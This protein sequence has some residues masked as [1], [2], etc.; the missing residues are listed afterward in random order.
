MAGPEFPNLPKIELKLKPPFHAAL[1][2]ADN[3]LTAYMAARERYKLAVQ[4]AGE[5]PTQTRSRFS[6]MSGMA[7]I[8]RVSRLIGSQFRSSHSQQVSDENAGQPQPD[9]YRTFREAADAFRT[10]QNTMSGVR[11]APDFDANDWRIVNKLDVAIAVAQNKI[12]AGGHIIDAQEAPWLQDPINVADGRNRIYGHQAVRPDDQSTISGRSTIKPVSPEPT[13]L[14]EFAELQHQEARESLPA[15][16]RMP[17]PAQC[18]AATSGITSQTS[19]TPDADISMGDAPKRVHEL[20]NSLTT[21]HEHV[22]KLR[23]DLR[24]NTLAIQA[25]AGRAGEDT[26]HAVA[27]TRA[28]LTSG[29]HDLRRDVEDLKVRCADLRQI[30]S[31]GT[32]TLA[33]TMTGNLDRIA[34]VLDHGID[35]NRRSRLDVDVFDER[36]RETPEQQQHRHRRELEDL[37]AAQT[38]VQPALKSLLY[39][40]VMGAVP[41]CREMPT[42]AEWMEAAPS[43][44]H[45]LANALKVYEKSVSTLAEQLQRNAS[46]VEGYAQF[47]DRAVRLEIEAAS[48]DDIVME[49]K[50]DEAAQA[51][52]AS[53]E[54]VTAVEHEMSQVMTH[55]RD[56]HAALDSVRTGLERF[57]EDPAAQSIEITQQLRQAVERI[58]PSL[59]SAIERHENHEIDVYAIDKQFRAQ[60]RAQRLQYPEVTELMNQL[61]SLPGERACL[62]FAA[63]ASITDEPRIQMMADAFS[64]LEQE[65]RSLDRRLARNGSAVKEYCEQPQTSTLAA[66][67]SAQYQVEHRFESIAGH[68]EIAK[69]ACAACELIQPAHEPARWQKEVKKLKDQVN[70]LEYEVR[71]EVLRN[72]FRGV[73]LE[74]LQEQLVVRRQVLGLEQQ[75]VLEPLAAVPLAGR[76]VVRPRAGGRR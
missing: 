57:E 1:Q 33:E 38:K 61:K 67:K 59:A 70:H 17:T 42:A 50:V 45:G 53:L 52:E 29:L 2:A 76:R 63:N 15:L 32:R 9:I 51:V 13:V 68:C 12:V 11:A 10:L 36:F 43:Q 31:E 16:E 75:D 19:L 62:D 37:H 23:K 22:F 6:V 55:L 47:A 72:Q 28:K 30:Q 64:K 65:V 4:A 41:L 3:D 49:R 35:R 48:K 44:M 34:G 71:N 5:T 14:P 56:A 39:P 8:S 54:D 20:L 74:R 60:L 73:D 24:E 25:Y 58:G 27:E 40:A 18:V 66:A 69:R 7:G 46:V 26:I 21:Y